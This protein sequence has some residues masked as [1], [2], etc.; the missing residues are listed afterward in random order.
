MFIP[1]QD[2]DFLPIPDTRVKKAP[3]NHHQLIGIK[4][5]DSGL[6]HLENTLQD[7]P[8]VDHTRLQLT[9]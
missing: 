2:L 7:E 4:T 8:L 5:V 3:D 9:P 1:D 6:D